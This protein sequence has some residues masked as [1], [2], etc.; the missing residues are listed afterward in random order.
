MSTHHR[1]PRSA[2]R[3]R[4]ALLS[5]GAVIGALCILTALASVLFNLTP[6][7]FR[8]GSMEP[9]IASGS[10]AMARSVPATELRAGD[11]VS[12][13]TDQDVRVTHRIVAVDSAAGNTAL[14]TLQGDANPEPDARPYGVT[15]AERILFHIDH[16][17]YVAVWLG[18]PLGLLV[19]GV[20]AAALAW[21]AVRPH[22]RRTTD[23]EPKPRPW[24]VSGTPA[25]VVLTLS[26]ITTVG[27]GFGHI[28]GTAAV[29]TDAATAQT[30]AFSSKSEFV[31]KVPGT[32]GCTGRLIVG[33]PDPVAL[34]WQH[35]GAP[36]QY[37]I[38]LRDLE[39]R[40]WR[41]WDVTNITVAQGGTIS[42]EIYGTGL[43]QRSLIWQYHAE[44]HTMLPGGTVS[45]AWTGRLVSQPLGLLGRED[46]NY[47]PFGE[48]EGTPAYVQPPATLTCVTNTA[49]KPTKAT[50]T[51]PHLG[52]GYTYQ[53]SV[54]NPATSNPVSTTAVS[55]V[56]TTAGAPVTQSV[57]LSDLD[58]GMITTGTGIAEVRALQ[59]GASSTGFVAYRLDISSTTGVACAAP[60]P[61]AR[62]AQAAAPATSSTTSPPPPSSSVSASV[63][64]P[65]QSPDAQANSEAPEPA[66]RSPTPG[67][68][69]EDSDQIPLSAPVDSA[70][71]NY[72]AQLVRSQDR[73]VAVI[74]SAAG[75]E[76]YRTTAS[77]EDTLTWLPGTDELRI[78]GPSG[79]WSV[80][81]SAGVWTKAAVTEPAP[82]PPAASEPTATPE[83]APAPP[84]VDEPPPAATQESAPESEPIE[85]TPPD[86]PEG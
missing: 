70:T 77:A 24:P 62:S 13:L 25:P 80:S 6:L 76:E 28:P 10:F 50:L 46:L 21:I 15:S 64:S 65:Q 35:V 63:S 82:A 53:L 59:A 85:K 48:R 61:G 81:K 30:G 75:T 60:A 2:T 38:I 12:V 32:V 67:P 20:G 45:A 16:L 68:E 17:G 86:T 73:P 26:V 55:A 83:P 29:F 72:S 52:S 34:S 56:P 7:V 43:P 78:T 71:G 79:T 1:K 5:V 84:V 51:W 58:L 47:S 42:Y 54:R 23:R 41:T 66:P 4:D 22:G 8:S 69:A 74:N 18:T 37:R 44:V 31:P 9:T 3:I 11:V 39:G 14:L 33:Q 27:L 40:V 57:A 36:Y 49:E 19:L